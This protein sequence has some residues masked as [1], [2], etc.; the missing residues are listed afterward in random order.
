[1]A[2]AIGGLL[3]GALDLL[4]A[5]SFAAL[6]GTAPSRVFE[7]IASGVL[8][9]AARGGGHGVSILGVAC[10]FG[11]SV[12][13]AACFAAVAWRL[14]ALT[15]RPLP[16]SIGFGLVVFLCMRLVVLPLSAYPHPVSFK[17]LA[18]GLDLLSH[19]FL[20]AMPMVVIAGRA[21]RARRTGQPL[22]RG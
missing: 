4:F 21:I 19:M 3:G 6:Q 10:H 11:L 5:V 20:F 7:A 12:V 16:V 2:V 9:E 17:P 8:G 22:R 14:P 1:M 15:R 13:W 18:S